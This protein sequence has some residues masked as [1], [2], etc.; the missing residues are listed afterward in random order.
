MAM[1]TALRKMQRNGQ[2]RRLL[3]RWDLDTVRTP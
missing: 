2:Y 3:V 1:D